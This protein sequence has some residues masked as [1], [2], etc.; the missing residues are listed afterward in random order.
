L[1]LIAMLAVT[2]SQLSVGATGSILGSGRTALLRLALRNGARFPSRSALTI[3]LMSA[4]SFLILAISAFRI[5]P[6][7]DATRRDTGT[8]G[9]TLVAESDQPIY[10]DLNNAD[11]RADLGLASADEKKLVASHATFYQFRVHAGDDASCLNLY[12]TTQPRVLG[13][14]D[15]LIDRGG[16]AW[17]AT[18]AT[19]DDERNNPW[20]LLRPKPATIDQ[21]PADDAPVPVILDEATAIYSLHLSG[22]GDTLSI[23]DG[24]G[25]TLNLYV[26]GLLRNSLL[27]GVILMHESAVLK[28]FP[29]VSGYRFFLIDAPQAEA[30]TVADLVNNWL[31][32]YGMDVVPSRQ[33]LENFMAVQNTYL[34]TFR[35]LGGLGLLLGTLGL[36]SVQLRNILER[37]TEL[38]LL[39]AAGFAR[40]R[41]ARLV[42]YESTALLVAGLAAGAIA[43]IVALLP[44]LG[45]GEAAIPW[46]SLAGT[47]AVVLV[48]GVLAS[49]TAVRA[50][51]TAPLLESLRSK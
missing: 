21:I 27:Q 11:Q 25:R 1:V 22:P 12:Q 15:A 50:V 9:F 36:A 46:L 45:Q 4:A 29:D 35:S 47:I 40:G 30:P 20:L 16:F 48:A 31:G 5:D 42:L 28:H 17:G 13:V 24:R 7:S 26:A 8:G 10:Q 2:W 14:P 23:A 32:D 33:R 19:F 34:E 6:P 39:R 37:R 41:L 3:G 18:Q 49:L 43:A 38:A 44:H 51:L